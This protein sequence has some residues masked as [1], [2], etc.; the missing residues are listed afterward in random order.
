MDHWRAVL[1][2]YFACGACGV[3]DY[4]F[5]WEK[6]DAELLAEEQARVDLLYG[7][8]S[9]SACRSMGYRLDSWNRFVESRAGSYIWNGNMPDG[10]NAIT[11]YQME[12][13]RESDS[14]KT[15]AAYYSSQFG[16]RNKDERPYF[17]DPQPISFEPTEAFARDK[18]EEEEG[19]KISEVWADTLARTIW[20]A[21]KA[22]HIT[23]QYFRGACI[24]QAHWIRTKPPKTP[25]ELHIGT[26]D[27]FCSSTGIWFN[28]QLYPYIVRILLD[29]GKWPYLMPPRTM[30]ANAPLGYLVA[31]KVA[32]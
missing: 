2:V 15:S 16:L 3:S 26:G 1:Y 27:G 7:S 21:V 4:S 23:S 20:L 13:E 30:I 19:V 6:T 18:H 12:I 31:R 5:R 14:Q 32:A 11:A 9:E 17:Q 29:E 10:P 8:D 25:D 28:T 22:R 24:D